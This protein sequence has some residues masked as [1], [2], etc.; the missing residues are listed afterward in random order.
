MVAIRA[1]TATD[2]GDGLRLS[3][4]AGWNQVEA[5]WRRFL[6]LGPDGSFVA[7]MAGRVVGTV[8]TCRFGPIGWVAMLLVEKPHR[9][10]G[11]GRRLLIRALEH[12]ES[13]GVRSIRLDATQMGRPLYESLGFRMDYPLQ[14][15]VGMVDGLPLAEATRPG[16]PSDLV[17][18]ADLDGDATGTD[19]FA[20]LERLVR[21]NPSSCLVRGPAGGPILGF[22]L[23]RPGTTADQIGPC[24]ADRQAGHALLDE[25]CRRLAGRPL[26]IDVPTDHAEAVAWAEDRG[27]KTSRG[28]WRMTR[29]AAVAED[30]DRLW[31]S[32]GPEMG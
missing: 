25:A 30:L 4:E 2:L 6:A 1:L 21:D 26:M 9:G 3:T 24:I 15:H 29:G 31:A 16:Q 22:V 5:D 23:W 11:I 13:Q 32:S 27:L 19:R 12:L 18:I 17:P 28:F 8:T 7:E 10:S 20:M 14:R